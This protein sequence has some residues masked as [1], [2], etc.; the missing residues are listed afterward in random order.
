MEI[1]NNYSRYD[2]SINSNTNIQK[3]AIQTPNNI[4]KNTDASYV[5]FS[6]RARLSKEFNDPNINFP[7]FNE[8]VL[9]YNSNLSLTYKS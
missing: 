1:R 8:D 2:S 6:Q 7:T 5:E 3:R 4:K 9:Q